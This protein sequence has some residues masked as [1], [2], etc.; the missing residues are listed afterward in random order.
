MI[1]ATK[2]ETSVAK[3]FVFERSGGVWEQTKMS[4]NDGVDVWNVLRIALDGD[5]GKT[6]RMWF[7]EL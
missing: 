5:T 1:S 6:K 2:M 7:S 4:L 3:L